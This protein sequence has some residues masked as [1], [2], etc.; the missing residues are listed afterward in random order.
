MVRV[1]IR[2]VLVLLFVL[3][4]GCKEPEGRSFWDDV[5]IIDLNAAESEKVSGERLLRT[6]NFDV[7][8][9]EVPAENVGKLDDVWEELYDKGLKFYN[10]RAF[11][12]NL[13]RVGMGKRFGWSGVND[14]LRDAGGKRMA[15]IA[16]LLADGE[17]QDVHATGLDRP[18]EISFVDR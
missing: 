3:L 15:K 1:V 14:L 11:T 13:F 4:A 16:L 12:G 17:C 8:I 10:Y 6:A 2:A 9:Y 18:E 5:K 7:H